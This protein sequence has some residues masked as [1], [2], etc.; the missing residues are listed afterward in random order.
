M[1]KASRRRENRADRRPDAAPSPPPFVTR[2][3]AGLP[4][5]T[6]WVALRDFLPAAT[7]QLRL[8]QPA[9]SVTVVT[10]LP[11]GWPAL[12]RSDGSVLVAS[13]SGATSGDASRDLAAAL[14]QALDAEPG[15]PVAQ[16][17][18]TTTETPRL[19][20]LVDP[21]C[22][23]EV[24]LHEG[25][26]FWVGDQQLDD[27]AA[28]SLEQA[29]AMVVPTVRVEGAPSVYWV[30][31]AGR[32]YVRWVLPH[33]ESLA[34]DALARLYAADES[35]L[36]PDARLLGAFRTCGLLVPVWEV[37]VTTDPASLSDG[38]AVMAERLAEATASTSDLTPDERRARNGILGRQVTL[39]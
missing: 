18:A 8:V 27:D 38:V 30:R 11:T 3:F 29:N 25:F 15:T 21:A 2:P 16:P 10:V 13:Q 7:A 19:Q 26:Q 35:R 14:I 24:T 34:T 17:P 37:S 22:S 12:H 36:A 4:A 31:I 23:F 9:C 33:D 28:A 20:E 39:R 32:C 5:E 6:E 1:G